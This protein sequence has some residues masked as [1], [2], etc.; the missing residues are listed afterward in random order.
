M[1]QISC[2]ASCPT[3]EIG[4]IN[5]TTPRMQRILNKLLPKIFPITI[6]GCFR[7]IAAQAVT[8]SGNDVPKATKVNLITAWD[9]PKYAAIPTAPLI[10][11]NK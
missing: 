6:S 2:F 10:K 8:N 5:A 9:M 7:H 1:I 11:N 4:L 3:N